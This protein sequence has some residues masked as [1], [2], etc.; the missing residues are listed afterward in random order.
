MI[1]NKYLTQLEDTLN[2]YFGKKAPPIPENI[3]EFIVKYFPYLVIVGLVLTLPGIFI[4]F[5]LRSFLSP[6][7]YM[8]GVRSGF[9]FSFWGLF[10]IAALVLEIMALPGLFKR[11]KQSWEYLFYASLITALG[12]L[13]SLNL[14]SLIIGALI[15]FY[16]LFQ[17]KPYY[18]N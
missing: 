4:A 10:S 15:S 12:S 2:L 14:G 3:K 16:L 5:G 11:S 13:L 17:I 6:Y 1:K 18:K 9:I 7:T 8:G